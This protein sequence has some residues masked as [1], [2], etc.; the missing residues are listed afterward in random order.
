[1]PWKFSART[2]GVLE[3]IQTRHP[4]NT[5]RNITTLRRLFNK[6]SWEWW[7]VLHWTSFFIYAGSYSSDQDLWVLCSMTSIVTWYHRSTGMFYLHFW[8]KM[9][10]DTFHIIFTYFHTRFTLLQSIRFLN[11]FRSKSYLNCKWLHTINP[12]F[13]KMYVDGHTIFWGYDK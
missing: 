13:P 7:A 2:V 10:Q 11:I 12:S 8:Q 9:I 5:I 3:E 4:L 6:I 1:M